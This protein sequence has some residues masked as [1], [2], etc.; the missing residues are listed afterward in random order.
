MAFQ[1]VDTS[2]FQVGI[3]RG[4]PTVTI[5]ENGQLAFSAALADVL[6]RE[7]TLVYI[8]VDP[9]ARVAQLQGVKE[10]PKGKEKSCLK[11][12][13]PKKGT[14]CMVSF[15]GVLKAKFAD[16]NYKASGSQTLSGD[17]VKSNADKRV[18]QFSVPQGTLTAKPKVKRVKKEKK[19][20]AP[21]APAVA[22][23]DVVDEEIS[24]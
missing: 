10:A 7:S 23:A 16:Y 9:E 20:S 3:K 14:G 8:R 11:I 19:A 12:A 21:A 2:T 1:E 18:I 15:A 17:A 6:T 5:R 24:I 13:W 4:G 22:P